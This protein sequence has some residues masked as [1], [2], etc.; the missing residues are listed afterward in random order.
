MQHA[1]HADE[2]HNWSQELQGTI[3][4]A[5]YFGYVLTHIPGGILSVKYG[6]KIVL[7]TGMFIA[8]IFSLLTPIFIKWGNIKYK[9][10]IY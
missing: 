8:A 3:L 7:G 4:S 5:F 10:L 2:L 1:V 9:N 6:G